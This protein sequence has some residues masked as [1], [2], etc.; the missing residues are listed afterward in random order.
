MIM[1]TSLPHQLTTF[2]SEVKST[3]P[4]ISGKISSYVEENSSDLSVYSQSSEWIFTLAEKMSE[5]RGW[6]NA[7]LLDFYADFVVDYLRE[8]ERFVA[9]GVFSNAGRTFEDVRVDVYEDDEH[10]TSYLVGLLL[11]YVIFPH[12]YAQYRF[13]VDEYLP[14]L[15]DEARCVEFGC[16]HG[17]FLAETLRDTKKRVVEGYD[18]SPAALELAHSLLNAAGVDKSRAHLSLDDVV[19]NTLG[20]EKY[21]G[22]T[23]AG[24]LEH[25][26]NPRGFLE[27]VREKLSDTGYFFVMLPINT[28]HSDHLILFDE[29]SD[30]QNLMKDGG[31]R[32]IKERIVPTEKGDW[33]FL[34]ENKIPILYVGVYQKG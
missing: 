2:I 19:S 30:C 14:L 16:G 31:Y 22:M 33:N 8:Q 1:M 11:S 28:A 4:T 3:F 15:P 5:E 18:V 20:S 29:P 21:D 32:L 6:D 12:H 23:A 7:Q 10:M 9:S 17:L 27:R 34:K 26:E 25:I 24:L 13:F